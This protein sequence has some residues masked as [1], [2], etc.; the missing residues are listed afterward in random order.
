M[1]EKFYITYPLSLVLLIFGTSAFGQNNV[2]N[3]WFV[4][5]PELGSSGSDAPNKAFSIKSSTNTLANKVSDCVSYTIGNDSRG[6]VYYESQSARKLNIID[7]GTQ[8]I[9]GTVDHTSVPFDPHSV[10]G[11]Y[12]SATNKHYIAVCGPGF[13]VATA[14]ILIYDVTNVT[15]TTLVN[16]ITI[17][18]SVVTLQTNSVTV[19]SGS[20]A[21]RMTG[22]DLYQTAYT[23]AATRLF[24]VLDDGIKVGSTNVLGL[25][26]SSRRHPSVWLDIADPLNTTTV[27]AANVHE[28]TYSTSTNA[29]AHYPAST[30]GASGSHQI[31][32]DPTNDIVYISQGGSGSTNS[33]CILS[34]H[35]SGSYSP[36][37]VVYRAGS[38]NISP[39]S[40][41]SNAGFHG[42]YVNKG[43]TAIFTGRAGTGIKQ[44]E[45][46]AIKFS[47]QPDGTAAG[48]ITANETATSASFSVTAGT[49]VLNVQCTNL[50]PDESYMYSSTL[51]SPATIWSL[52]PG[53]LAIIQRVQKPGP[54]N[55]SFTNIDIHS[56]AFTLSDFGDAPPSYGIAVH[57]LVNTNYTMD[58]LRIGATIDGDTSAATS[59]FCDGD[60]LAKTGGGGTGLNDDEDGI[61]PSMKTSAIGLFYGMTGSYSIPGIEVKNTTSNNATLIGWIDFD[62]DGVFEPSEG[63]SV[64]VPI[65]TTSVDLNWSIPAT[66]TTGGV[67]LRLRLSTDATLSVSTPSLPMLDGEAEDY[68]Y[69]LSPITVSGNVFYDAN[70]NTIYGLAG[71][72]GSG[73]TGTT[74]NISLYAYLIKNGIIIDTAHV[75]ADGSYTFPNAPQNIGSASIAIGTN[76]LA[77]GASASGIINFS[78]DLPP[79]WLFT[80]SSSALNSSGNA[81]TLNINIST[82]PITDQNFGVQIIALQVELVRFSAT[83]QNNDIVLNWETAMDKNILEFKIE[84]SRDGKHFSETASV[85]AKTDNAAL[86]QYTWAELSAPAGPSFFRLKLVHSNGLNTYSDISAVYMTKTMRAIRVYPTV[87]KNNL[88]LTGVEPG[89]MLAI[90][91]SAGQ[92]FWIEKIKDNQVIIN[93]SIFATG[94]YLITVT[95]N[96]KDLFSA[97][98]L[99]AN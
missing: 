30:G 29:Y 52:N 97:K 59:N 54:A 57:N 34:F 71:T 77:N 23:S 88:Y 27:G 56:R 58:K 25:T 12:I 75:A 38:S 81:N 37:Y 66:V 69:P 72:V 63:T 94:L 22:M 51:G 79:S 31:S 93:C 28:V 21:S 41:L 82:S 14:G 6:Y 83:R 55:A 45:D 90:Y 98:I 50:T 64:P 86:N 84:T 46:R 53:T 95:N 33:N 36:T 8:S 91:N 11:F 26:G 65:N 10:Q 73:E 17:P 76:S 47:V 20:S 68:Y 40:S 85:N 35:A 24:C 96:R 32:Y 15:A 74:C 92:C 78:G 43:G 13:S 19:S 48:I 1:K 70:N 49:G 39:A 60:N 9:V 80:G 16:T 99:K 61:N 89:Q 44:G 67:V 2:N 5:Y 4:W 18:G 87:T 42:I 62:H 7:P 3:P